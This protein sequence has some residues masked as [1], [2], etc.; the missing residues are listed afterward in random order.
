MDDSASFN[1][2]IISAHIIEKRA[3]KRSENPFFEVLG[4]FWIFTKNKDN[5][6][7]AKE[8]KVN[9]L[10]NM[11]RRGA[12]SMDNKSTVVLSPYRSCHGTCITASKNIERQLIQTHIFNLVIFS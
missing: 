2:C 1:C 7:I 6:Y 11:V 10:L 8:E 5:F 12:S 9:F 3:Q 4:F